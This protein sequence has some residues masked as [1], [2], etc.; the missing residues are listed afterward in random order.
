MPTKW[1]RKEIPEM[2]FYVHGTPLKFEVLE[3]KDDALITE[4]DKAAQMGR[5]GIIPITQAQFEEESKKK[6]NGTIS[7]SGYKQRQQR[8]ELSA[9]QLNQSRVVDAVDGLQFTGGMFARPQEREHTPH[10][11]VG[12]RQNA[13]GPSGARPM[14]DPIELP[15]PLDLK[16]PTAKL[17]EVAAV[18]S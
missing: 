2:P 6:P 11:Q 1:Y 13:A 17:S 3:T 8:Q 10:N 15:K 4:L 7:E 9:Q 14:P 12:F 5:G 16:P 18:K